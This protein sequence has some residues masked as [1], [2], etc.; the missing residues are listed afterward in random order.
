MRG[1]SHEITEHFAPGDLSNRMMYAV[2]LVEK[3]HLENIEET[4][5]HEPAPKDN[6]PK[7]QSV[8]E[9]PQSVSGFGTSPHLEGSSPAAAPPSTPP[10]VQDI[11]IFVNGAKQIRTIVEELHRLNALVFSRGLEYARVHLEEAWKKYTGGKESVGYIAPIPVTSENIQRGQR[12]YQDIFSPINS[13]KVPIYEFDAEGNIT[14]RVVH[15]VTASR[16]VLVGTN[17]IETGMTIDTLKYCV[18]TGFVK[19]SSF[20]PVFGCGVL[21]DKAVTQA[22]SRQRRG[23]V[24]RKAPGVFYPAYTKEVHAAMRPRLPPEIVKADITPFMLGVVI[25]ETEACVEASDRKTAI[26]AGGFQMNQFD[27]NWFVMQAQKRFRAD[28]INFLQPPSADALS[29]SMEKLYALGFIDATYRPTL[30]GVYANKFRKVRLES[31]RMI[32]ASYHMGGST[33]D[34]ITIAAFIEVGFKVGI[35]RRKYTPRNPL[36]VKKEAVDYYYRLFFGC[37]LVEY[38]FIWD[39]FMATVDEVGARLARSARLDKKKALSSGH[40]EQWARKSGFN[41]DG[42]MMVVDMRD[43]IISDML[44]MGLNPYYNGLGIPRGGYRLTRILQSNS[45]EGL[46]EVRAIKRCIYEG[47]RMNVFVWNDGARAY[48]NMHRHYPLVVE[49]PLVA[50]LTVDL[51]EVHQ[52]L[53]RKLYVLIFF[54]HFQELLLS[55]SK[56]SVPLQNE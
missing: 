46:D 11:L 1:E 26:A 37:E 22:S 53:R 7:D 43:E 35:N 51:E 8:G 27:Q 12:E 42:L 55:Y 41:Y 2:D 28:G 10:P 13:V 6:G 34:L 40:V 15:E 33:L 25:E 4:K 44:T 36:K 17:A 30:F 18:D 31:V 50:P 45:Q 5:A 54:Y 19:Q 20:D 47:Y 21:M 56:L 48:F 9:T 29:Y 49:T 32:L 3:I 39:E 23:R 52:Q 14:E 16:R 24:G 38:L